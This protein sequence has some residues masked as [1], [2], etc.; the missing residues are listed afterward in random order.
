MWDLHRPGIEPMSPALAGRFLTTVPPGKPP[1]HMFLF[2]SFEALIIWDFIFLPLFEKSLYI[3]LNC[4]PYE[5]R[6]YRPYRL[7]LQHCQSVCLPSA[8]AALSECLAHNRVSINCCRIVSLMSSIFQWIIVNYREE[9]ALLY[10]LCFFKV[11]TNILCF[12]LNVL[13]FSVM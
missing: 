8:F 9:S 10:Y 4:K 12:Y 3:P 7:L 13:N 2:F 5:G 11:F 1:F 6:N